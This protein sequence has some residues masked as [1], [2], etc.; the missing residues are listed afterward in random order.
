MCSGH[1]LEA[2]SV[3]RRLFDEDPTSVITLCLPV[4]LMLTGIR[5]GFD[6]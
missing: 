1:G 4:F 3:G 5:R 2:R 6:P